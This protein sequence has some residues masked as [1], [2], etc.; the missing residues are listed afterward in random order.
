[1]STARNTAQPK[2]RRRPLTKARAESVWPTGD[3]LRS[4][5][6]SQWHTAQTQSRTM[7]EDEYVV[8]APLDV[9]VSTSVERS[10]CVSSGKGIIE[11]RGSR[12]SRCKQQLPELLATA[13]DRFH[14]SGSSTEWCR[15]RRGRRLAYGA[16]LPS[17]SVLLRTRSIQGYRWRPDRLNTLELAAG[18]HCPRIKQT[19]TE[20]RKKMMR[21]VNGAE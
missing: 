21:L 2:R 1:M 18:G 4:E 20:L 12:T 11:R 9:R 15:R 10:K 3:H 5:A 7:E 16:R 14:S 13:G 8:E 6:E 19:G 17:S